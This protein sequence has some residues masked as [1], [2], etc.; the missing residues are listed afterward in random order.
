M[1][2]ALVFGGG[3][4]NGQIILQTLIDKNFHVTNIGSSVFEHDMVDNILINWQDID[5]KF[6]HKTLNFDHPIDFVFFNQ[7]S[8]SLRE[9][10]FALNKSDTLKQW[11]LIKDWQQSMWISCQMPFMVL[12]R[13]SKNLHKESSVGWMLS[14]YVDYNKSG[15]HE[16]PDYS[17]FK[18]FNNLAMQC[19]ANQ[20]KIN[21]FG[22][23]PDFKLTDSKNVLQQIIVEVLHTTECHAKVY[24]F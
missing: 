2:H 10:D 17:S 11:K 20:N 19:F 8:S 4:K 1:K 6:I 12:H 14:G 3:S 5:L 23:M 21:T 22:I 24:K 16:H 18:F 9:S 13:L 15:V 7:N